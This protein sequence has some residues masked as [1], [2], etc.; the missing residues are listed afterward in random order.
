MQKQSQQAKPLRAIIAGGGT[1]GHVFPAIAIALALK[2]KLFN[3][4]LLFVG[5][6]G[7]MEMRKVPEAGFRIIGLDIAGIQRRIT[8]K[9]VLVPWKLLKSI[10]AAKRIIKRYK[11]DIVIGVG[12]YASGPVLWAAAGQKIPILLQEQNSYPGLTNRILGKKAQKICV[13]YEGLDKYFK[14]DKLYLTGNPVRQDIANI[15]GKKAEAL[16]YFGLIAKKPVLFVTGGSLGARSINESVLSNL[17]LFVNK[18][19]QL[20]WQTG[21]HFID[22]AKEAIKSLPEAHLYVATFIDRMDYA[23]AAADVVVSRAGAIAVSEICLVRKP[24]ILIPSP[25]VAEDHQTKNA[26]A[27]VTHHAAIHIKD[28][29]AQDKLGEE[30]VNL[31][32][33]DE[34]KHRLKEKMAGMS[35]RNAADRIAGVALS[36]IH[37]KKQ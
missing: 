34:K 19:I 5:A 1:G 9:N 20:I 36:M 31:I 10:V 33:D 16:T 24:A 3:I 7:R 32:F 23:Y 35:Y 27:L 6:R 2:K 4:Q 17:R 28:D 29:E 13:A 22:Q 15:E 18:D 11:P 25:N 37:T 8:W 21:V 30:V 12:G 14:K 26:M